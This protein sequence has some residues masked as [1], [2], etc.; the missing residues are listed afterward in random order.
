MAAFEKELPFVVDGEIVHMERNAS[1]QRDD[2]KTVRDNRKVRAGRRESVSDKRFN[3]VRKFRHIAEVIPSP[4]EEDVGQPTLMGFR[5]REIGPID[6]LGGPEEPIHNVK[7]RIE[8]AVVRT[9]AVRSSC[10]T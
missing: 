1:H 4:V 3:V 9:R 7:D 8:V 2:E 5:E 10:T 6:L